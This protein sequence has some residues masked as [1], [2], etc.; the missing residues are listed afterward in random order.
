MKLNPQLVERA[1][2]IKERHQEE[3]EYKGFV[4]TL[5]EAEKNKH[6]WQ[7]DQMVGISF[8][9]A[10][11]NYYHLGAYV[12]HPWKPWVFV[13]YPE[14]KAGWGNDNLASFDLHFDGCWTKKDYHYRDFFNFY[15]E[16]HGGYRP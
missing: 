5:T 15:N 11:R 13:K 14:A 9:N 4:H 8:G 16:D 2:E 3:N 7:R 12:L 1:K 10:K 6:K